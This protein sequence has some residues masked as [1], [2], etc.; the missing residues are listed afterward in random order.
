MPEMSRGTLLRSSWSAHA[1]GC[2][3]SSRML[4]KRVIDADTGYKRTSLEVSQ[5]L[6]SMRNG[7]W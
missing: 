7:H 1:E 6:I 2:V 3:G 4:Q 5:S